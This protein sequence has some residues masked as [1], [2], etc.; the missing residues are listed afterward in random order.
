MTPDDL[1]NAY[2]RA[3]MAD[4]LNRPETVATIKARA[5]REYEIECLEHQW[6]LPERGES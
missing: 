6:N 4:Y 5:K 3:W 2:H 1:R